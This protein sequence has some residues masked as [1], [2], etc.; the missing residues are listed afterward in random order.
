MTNIDLSK[1]NHWPSN[2]LG[3]NFQDQQP[4]FYPVNG[5]AFLEISEAL[6]KHGWVLISG[7]PVGFD[8]KGFAQWLTGTELMPQDQGETVYDV[9]F[10]PGNDRLS[11]SKSQNALRPHTEA[12]YLYKPPKYLALWGV[13]PSSCGSGHTTLADGYEFFRSLTEEEQRKLIE[14]RCPFVSKD[15]EKQVL[16]PIFQ[17]LRFNRAILR[18][19]YNIVLY[20]DPSPDVDAE[21]TVNDPFLKEICDRLLQ[22]FEERHEAIRIESNS[23]LIFDNYRI[24]HSRTQYLDP[25]RHLQRIW[26]I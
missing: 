23:L 24:I 10:V 2:L 19:S 9:K 17:M 6:K 4:P 26:L 11:D 16:A 1:N 14:Y 21:P 22:F 13:K 8:W 20:R 7:L 15:G 18:F 5:Q 12:S 25:A 3:K